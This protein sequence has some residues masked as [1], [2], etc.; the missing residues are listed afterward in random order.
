MSRRIAIEANSQALAAKFAAKRPWSVGFREANGREHCPTCGR[1]P[2]G[3]RKC[4]ACGI[5]FHPNQGYGFV[6]SR[7]AC[8]VGWN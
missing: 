8:P 1:S 2:D 3:S 5:V 4:T 7:A 6:C